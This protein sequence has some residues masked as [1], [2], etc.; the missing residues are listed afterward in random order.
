MCLTSSI[1]KMYGLQC[2]LCTMYTHIEKI[3]PCNFIFLPQCLF[4]SFKGE[5][6]HSYK[7]FNSVHIKF[8]QYASIP[9]SIHHRHGNHEIKCIHETQIKSGNTYFY[10]REVNETSHIARCPSRKAA[11]V[12]TLTSRSGLVNL[13]DVQLR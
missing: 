8:R 11:T 3:F 1:L 10:H 5:T 7:I 6:V 12:H 13:L 9:L 2:R 4:S